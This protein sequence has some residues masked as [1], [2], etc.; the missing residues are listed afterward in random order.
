MTAYTLA[1]LRTP[2]INADVLDYIERIQ[3][4]MD[5]YGGRFLVHGAP[6][7]VREGSWPGTV[8]ILEFPDIGSTASLVRVAGVSADSAAA[9]R[10]HRRRHNHRRRRQRRLCGGPHRGRP[11]RSVAPARPGGTRNRSATGP[12]TALRIEQRARITPATSATR[13]QSAWRKVQAGSRRAVKAGPATPNDSEVFEVV[14]PRCSTRTGTDLRHSFERPDRVSAVGGRQP[15][16]GCQAG[17]KYRP[18]SP[19]WWT[20]LPSASIT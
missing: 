7:E 11:T 10:P 9:H 18:S 5:P 16:R 20:S 3:A 1:H 4:T 17:T 15:P 2:Q 13:A 14:E 19:T 6:V 12:T 8:V